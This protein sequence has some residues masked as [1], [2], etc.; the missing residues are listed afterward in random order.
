MSLV[1]VNMERCPIVVHAVVKTRICTM[2]FQYGNDPSSL[3]GEELDLR[4]VKQF[5]YW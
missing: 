2:T 3:I 1:V 5:I 4:E